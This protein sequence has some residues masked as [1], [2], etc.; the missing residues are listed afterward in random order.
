[1]AAY[2]HVSQ[3]VL[4]MIRVL[5]FST[6]T[7]EII[8]SQQMSRNRLVDFFFNAL[9]YAASTT[10]SFFLLAATASI[11][12]GRGQATWPIWYAINQL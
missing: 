6:R 3:A 2:K 1:M 8:P 11:L 9:K 5:E 7:E 10:D 4:L 12:T